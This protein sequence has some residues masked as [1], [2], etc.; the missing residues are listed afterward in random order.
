MASTL[1]NVLWSGG[2]DSTY[3]I[4]KL[5]Q[6]GYKVNAY[7]IEI[8]NNPTKVITELNAIKK[9]LPLFNKFNFEYK[10]ILTSFALNTD[11]LTP[12]GMQ[13]S[14]IWLLSAYFLND[15]VCIGYVMNDDSISYIADYLKIAE[16]LSLLR[17]NAIQLEF[18]LIKT[19]KEDIIRL[20]PKEY[21]AVVVSCENPKTNGSKCK[22]CS[23]CVRHAAALLTKK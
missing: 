1:K 22:K 13:Q 23:A 20:L 18:P 7:Y 19:K 10:G 6:D 21:L 9:M 12:Q 2:L 5:L 3:L 11:G 17:Y 4:Y 15:P 16:S 8:K 14:P